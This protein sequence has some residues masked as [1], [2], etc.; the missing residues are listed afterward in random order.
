MYGRCLG[1]PMEGYRSV[2]P[3]HTTAM[4]VGVLRHPQCV[5]SRGIL[6][7]GTDMED[8]SVTLISKYVF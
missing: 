4:Q 8:F 1:V 7:F 6:F 3:T 2:L 5:R